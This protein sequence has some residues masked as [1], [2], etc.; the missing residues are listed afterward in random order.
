MK[1]YNIFVGKWPFYDLP[2]TTIDELDGLHK[3]YG[4]DGGYVSSL[5]SIFYN[6]FY[7]SEYKLSEILKDTKYHHVVTPNPAFVES[8]VTLERCIADFNVKGIRIHPEYH[9]FKLTD[10][11][12]RHV[13]DIAR[14]Y[15]LPVFVTARMHDE[16]M[17]HMIN[18][19]EIS[20]EELKSFVIENSDIKIILCQFKIHEIEAIKKELL[21]LPNLYTDT[22]SLRVNLFGNA[23]TDIFKKAVY[24]S[25]YPLLHVAASALMLTELEGEEKEIFYSRGDVIEG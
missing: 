17:A 11:C 24:G 20:T 21:S 9:G 5:E 18:P 2:R 12:V 25:G 8:A 22:S 1:D 6:D 3:P 16:R 4:I 13:L 15:N 23:T 10:E 19:R 14:R 7:D